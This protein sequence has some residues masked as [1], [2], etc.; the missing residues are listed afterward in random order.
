MWRTHLDSIAGL[1]SVEDLARPLVGSV[2]LDSSPIVMRYPRRWR[3][4]SSATRRRLRA[5]GVLAHAERN[6]LAR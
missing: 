3:R 4:K 5:S 1:A 6:W 2:R